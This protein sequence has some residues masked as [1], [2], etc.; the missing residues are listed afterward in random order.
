MK[1]VKKILCISL[2]VIIIISLISSVF[3]ITGSIGNARMILR[4]KTGD[5]IEKSILV[6]NI[7]D[8]AVD[9]EIFSSG[10]LANYTTIIDK[11]FRLEPGEEKN[12]KFEI[13]VA[14]EGTTETKI[15][16]QFTPTAGK[17]G[18]GLSSTVIIIAE[19]G[20]GNNIFNP[21]NGENINNTQNSTITGKVTNPNPALSLTTIAVVIMIVLFIFLVLLLIFL[22]KG[23]NR[24]LEK[25][26][27]KETQ[28]T[29]PKKKAQE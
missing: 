27:Q 3:A 7:N 5:V 13:K 29:K 21:N 9:I 16:V 22:K 12:A 24:G 25:E 2:A 23:S 14:K 8:Q 17:D 10:D 20:N 1:T 4:A 15:N 6:R 19:Q 11:K 18:I 28:D 26:T